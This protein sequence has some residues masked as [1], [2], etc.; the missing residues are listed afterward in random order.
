M[1]ILKTFVLLAGIVFII[2]G[3]ASRQYVYRYK[4]NP[5]PGEKIPV[6]AY[7]EV[8]IDHIRY[9][10]S[11]NY[12]HLKADI[13]DVLQSELSQVFKLVSDDPNEP[14]DIR[15]MIDVQQFRYANQSWPMIFPSFFV[16]GYLGSPIGISKASV[17]YE[18]NIFD[19]N[20]NPVT[21][22][23]SIKEVKKWVGLYYNM[24]TLNPISAKFTSYV[25][26]QKAMDAIKP[27]ILADR[28]EMEKY[29]MVKSEYKRD[30]VIQREVVYVEKEG[31]EYQFERFSDVDKNIPVNKKKDPSR[32]A[33]II[34]NEDYATHQVDLS[35]EIDV[36]FARNDASA[37]K[38]YALKLLGIPEDNIIF[39]LDATTGQMNQ[40][41][42]KMNL[43]IK[44]TRGRA[45]VFVYYAG[46]G[47][48]DEETRTPFLMP[49]DVS[50]RNAADGIPLQ[51]LYDKLTEFPS[52]R[53]TVF[54]DACFSGG[55]RNQGL[56][57]ARGVKV[58][59]KASKYK[60]N[61]ISFTSSSGNQ[62]SLPLSAQKHGLFT[63]YLLKKLKESRGEI[64]YGALS[65]YLSDKISLQSVLRNDKEQ[66]PNT[67]TSSS[68]HEEWKSWNF[69]GH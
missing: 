35:S 30:T 25:A 20:N 37:F 34:G 8:N 5:V 57:A 53:V 11:R 33:L 40:A 44:N 14:Y 1:K 19:R 56:I 7:F 39:L 49:V 67:Y 46:H 31:A 6:A 32:F 10:G 64:Q 59:P 69:L 62:S 41:I 36:D 51:T 22:Y 48:P 55:A 23:Q 17:A 28:N 26:S 45:E 58:I 15:I 60:G 24:P 43:I 66:T 47:L 50:G 18:V 16:L 21:S 9:T 29:M 68:I 42:S 12:P 4:P 65:N 63:Y 3:C 2:S 52:R 27:Q 61:L 13:K 38:M 54:I